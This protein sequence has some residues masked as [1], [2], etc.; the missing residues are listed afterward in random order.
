MKFDYDEQ[1]QLLDDSVRR[2]IAQDYAFDTRRKIVA[3]AEGMSA[4]VWKTLAELGLLGL[5]FSAADGG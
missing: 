2:F 1:Q 3:S 5:P 4:S